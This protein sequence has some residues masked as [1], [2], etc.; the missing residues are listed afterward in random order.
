VAT[1]QYFAADE[2]EESLG[3]AW[4]ASLGGVVLIGR[5]PS[6]PTLQPFLLTPSV[7]NYL[8]LSVFVP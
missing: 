4:A 7:P 3:H 1:E 8:S 5:H 6:N 2:G